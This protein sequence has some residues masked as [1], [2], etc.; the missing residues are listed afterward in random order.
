MK[1]GI[2]DPYLDDLGGGEKYMMKLALCLSRKHEVVVFWDKKDDFKRLEQRFLFDLSKVKLSKNIFSPEVSFLKR[3]LT[4]RGFDAIIVLSDGSIPFVLSKKLFIHIQQPL[5]E[6]AL[7]S[8]RDRIKFS[9]INAFFCNSNYTKSFIDQ[10]Y[11]TRSIIVY[12]PVEI[13]K[14]AVKKENIILNVG[15]LRVKNV[16]SAGSPFDYKKQTVMIEAFKD[17]IKNGLK[18]WKFV[19]GVSVSDEDKKI[20]DAIQKTTEGFPIKF[21]VNENNKKLWDTYNRSKIYWHASGYGENLK[22]HPEYAEHFGIST[23]EAMGAGAV[24]VVFNAGGQKEIVTNGE[25]GFL[26]NSL[27]ELKEKTIEIIYNEKLWQKM[28]NEAEKRAGNFAGDRFCRG[29]AELIKI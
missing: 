10:S 19:L 27:E 4:S 16:D 29:I 9:R 14:K 20:F 23:V 8:F 12:P 13:F 15:R 26:W 11:N 2:F 18:N 7:K 28:S 22:E 6:F 3:I 1:I 24:P 25:N 21:L 5:K 17:M